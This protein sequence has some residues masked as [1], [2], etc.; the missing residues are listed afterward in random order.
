MSPT[1]ALL[2][3]TYATVPLMR[4][5]APRAL[6]GVRVV[7]LLDDSLL[8]D[9]IAA[10]AVP[11]P[12][13]Q[14]LRV[15]VEQ[16]AVLGA[17]AV[18]SCC[19]SIGDAMELIAVGAPL[20][21][22]RIDEAMAE[23]AV[24][25]GPRVVVLATVE[26]TMTPTVRLIE[27]AARAAGRDLTVTPTLIEGAF[28]ALTAGDAADHDAR[29]TRALEALVR[30]CDAVVLAQASTARVAAALPAYP[31][32]ILTSPVPGLRRARDR[33]AALEGAP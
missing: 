30:T 21:V 24:A 17:T 29:V 22:W 6:P 10:G 19:S 26:T 23:E 16:A 31:L 25:R 28:A 3:T 32:P 4:E 11:P 1:L 15:Y 7:N 2:H 12:V 18:M 9:V 33:L 5:L 8:A 27:R 13:M 14:R 20:P